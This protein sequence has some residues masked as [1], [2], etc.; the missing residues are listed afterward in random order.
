MLE[1]QEEAMPV[2][3]DRALIE[4]YNVSGPRY[5]SYP[6]VLQ[7][8]SDFGAADY[9]R[10][11]LD[12][13]RG[14]PPTDLSLYFHLPF[15]ARL[16]YYCACNKV[17][18]RDRSRAGAYLDRLAREISLQA[19]LYDRRRTVT[20]LH[21]GGG[22]PTFL[23]EEEMRR[24]MRETAAHFTLA[25]ADV[26][27][28]GIELDPRELRP[29]TLP[30]LREIGFNRVSLGI[31]DF[32][33]A[34]QKAVNRLQ[35]EALTG[36]VIDEARSLGF[37]SVSVDLIYGLPHQS[38][39][40]MA[41][42]LAK[43]IALDPD[44]I[45][46]Y[47]YAHLPDAFPPQRR[48]DAAT[49]PSPAVK[50]DLLKLCID[51]FTAAGYLYIGMDH[52]AKP[53][54]ALARAQNAGT[55]YRNFQGYSTHADC[56]LIGMGVTAIGTVGGNFYQNRKEIDAYTAAL[57][58]GELPIEKGLI[59]DA[60]DR[61]RRAVIMTLI[62][63]FALRYGD[64]DVDFVQHFAPELARLAPMAE[65]GL[66]EIDADGIRVTDKGRLLIRNVCM[67]F[68]RHLPAAAPTQ[69]FSKAI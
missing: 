69:R 46:I 22:T 43:V 21:W 1:R 39:E 26:G 55:L 65:S 30:T 61:V 67:V 13:N 28:F 42:T 23:S 17:V 25:A 52:F 20:Q 63:R 68:D 2:D 32:D 15:C 35:S 14:E 58:A 41:A 6:T 49:L 9:R 40:T 54:D 8:R 36:H 64:F 16:C 53:T 44:R 29:A 18:T 24:L 51:R 62:C 47:N 60:D 34:V 11:A 59:P 5:T 7:F 57:D 56:D 33:P 37:H 4:K 66:V 27:E 45:S 19:A 10:I 38:R 12:S 48:L 3:F 50:L 31:Q